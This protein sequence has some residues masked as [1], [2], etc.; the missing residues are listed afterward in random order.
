MPF[1]PT[2]LPAFYRAMMKTF[3]YEWDILFVI[4]V[5][6]LQFVGTD[7]IRVTEANKIFIGNTKIVSVSRTVIDDII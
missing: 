5:K 6:S 7:I 3:K 1:E 4:K 2:N